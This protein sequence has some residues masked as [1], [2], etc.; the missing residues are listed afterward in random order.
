MVGLH[1]G[2]SAFIRRDTGKL[3]PFLSLCPKKTQ[4]KASACKADRGSLPELAHASTLTLDLQ[5]PELRGSKFLLF[6]LPRVYH[7]VTARW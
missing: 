4:K 3:Y 1:D 5:P 2:I 6:K 7:F